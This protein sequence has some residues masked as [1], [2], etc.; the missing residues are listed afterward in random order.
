MKQSICDSFFFL[1]QAFFRKLLISLGIL[2]AILAVWI[3]G[4]QLLC[5]YWVFDSAEFKDNQFGRNAQEYFASI[6]PFPEGSVSSLL[7]RE[8]FQNGDYYRLTVNFPSEKTFDEYLDG[9]ALGENYSAASIQDI[10]FYV[11]RYSVNPYGNL[12]ICADEQ[13]STI[14]FFFS[15]GS[16]IDGYYDQ[17]E[18]TVERLAQDMDNYEIFT[19]K[20]V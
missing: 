3:G 15:D 16:L 7:L 20:H 17:N 13:C 18:P 8:E 11:A 2:F 6:E 19:H 1:W 10:N 12:I 14:D 9:L 5:R 4:Y